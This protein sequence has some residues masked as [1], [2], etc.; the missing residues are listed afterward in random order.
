MS[1][2]VLAWDRAASHTN[3]AAFVV[4]WGTNSGG[5][6]SSQ[7]IATNSTTTTVTNLNAG[8][9]YF[10][11]VTAKNV[12]GLESDPSNEISYTPVETLTFIGELEG[13]TNISGPWAVV[14]TYPPVQITVTNNKFFRLKSTLR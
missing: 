7:I 13:A 12:A 14:Y 5:Y 6:T 2:V 9:R 4:K 8:T 11:V 10:F 3:L 1:D